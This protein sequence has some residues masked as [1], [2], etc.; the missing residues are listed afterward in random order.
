VNALKKA[1]NK[2]AGISLRVAGNRAMTCATLSQQSPPRS[3]LFLPKIHVTNS[4]DLMNT[5][6]L[7]LSRGTHFLLPLLLLIGVAVLSMTPPSAFAQSTPPYTASVTVVPAV[8]PTGVQRTLIV[9]GIW[10]N[11]CIPLSAS[12]STR[13]VGPRQFVIITLQRAPD[14]VCTQATKRFSFTV[15]FTPTNPAVQPIIIQTDDGT[16]GGEGELSTTAAANI[17]P[18]LPIITVVPEVDVPKTARTIVISG[19]YQSGCPFAQPVIDGVNGLLI[20]GI[21]IRMDPVPTLV[22][23]NTNVLQPYRFELPY[24]PLEAGTQRVVVASS[25]GGIRSESQMRTVATQGKTRAVGNIGGVW[26]DPAT[27]G[28][29]LQFTHNFAGSDVVFGTWYL[30]DDNG[31]ARWLSIQNVV[32]QSGGTAFVGD[33]YQSRATSC[34]SSVPPCA[35]PSLPYPYPAPASGVDKIGTVRFTFTGL[36]PYS[37]TQPQGVAEAFSPQGQQLFVSNI[38]R[39]SF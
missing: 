16:R 1:H 9:D 35:R 30:Y 24:T 39:L 37:D 28:S 29:G 11:G 38:S 10:P 2:F 36:G 14:S 3:L 34:F 23:C 33:L 31:N 32:W 21:V 25:S 13:D 6:K 17:V 18:L 12:V 8:A 20:N 5:L 27:N 15:S 4:G 7:V 26:Y 19:Q 22:P